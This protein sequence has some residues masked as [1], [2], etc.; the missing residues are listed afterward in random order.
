MATASPLPPSPPHPHPAERMPISYEAELQLL[1]PARLCFERHFRWSMRGGDM[2]L[3]G[4][5]CMCGS[6]GECTPAPP[7]PHPS[8]AT[9]II[10]CVSRERANCVPSSRLHHQRIQKS[11]ATKCGTSSATRVPYI[12]LFLFALELLHRGHPVGRHPCTLLQNWG[13]PTPTYDQ[14]H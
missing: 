9:H 4:N 7:S 13:N 2:L 12:P 6:E 1:L 8:P 11:F 5:M 14:V 3:R 10:A